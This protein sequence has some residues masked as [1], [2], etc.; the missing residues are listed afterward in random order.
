MKD[1]Q[2]HAPRAIL[3]IRDI[4]ILLLIIVPFTFI[5]AGTALFV[6]AIGTS[7]ISIRGVI[8]YF[9]PRR[10]NGQAV[11]PVENRYTIPKGVEV[12]ELAGDAPIEI[13]YKHIAVLRAMEICPRILIVRCRK[14]E[15]IDSYEAD[16]LKRVV[17]IL[18]GRKTLIFFS[19]MNATIK[20]QFLNAIP[21]P[22]TLGCNVFYQFDEALKRAKVLLYMQ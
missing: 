9:G 14:I 3:T 15:Q 11:L 16:V 1:H 17:N 7:L 6:G 18:A 5:N 20:D 4:V 2:L 10:I 12:F 13:L 8:R 19:E 21:G 22:R